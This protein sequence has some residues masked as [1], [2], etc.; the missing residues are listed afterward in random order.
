MKE[1]RNVQSTVRPKETE[2]DAYSVYLNSDIKE[3]SVTEESGAYAGY[4]YNQTIYSKDEYI[5]LTAEENKALAG[6][7]T[8]TQMALCDVY[9]MI[10]G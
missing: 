7:L 6:Q 9:E 5:R 4:A 8:D 2:M 3:I 10:G 1:Y